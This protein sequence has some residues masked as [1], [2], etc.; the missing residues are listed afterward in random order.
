[1]RTEAINCL[2]CDGWSSVERPSIMETRPHELRCS[3]PCW[4]GSAALLVYSCVAWCQGISSMPTSSYILPQI[5]GASYLSTLQLHN[6]KQSH[7]IS[8]TKSLEFYNLLLGW[9]PQHHLVCKYF[10]YLQLRWRLI[11]KRLELIYSHHLFDMESG[12]SSTSTLMG[13]R[14]YRTIPHWW[15]TQWISRCFIIRCSGSSS[16]I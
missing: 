1:M 9:I 16:T 4:L 2:S 15:V 11:S 12:K 14:I 10:T 13:P 7:K 6:G 3:W 5:Y 8:I